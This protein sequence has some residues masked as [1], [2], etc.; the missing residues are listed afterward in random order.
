M[1][2]LIMTLIDIEKRVCP[3]S[4]NVWALKYSVQTWEGSYQTLE[5][6]NNFW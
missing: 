5:W 3:L 4:E 6:P 2:I 1:K